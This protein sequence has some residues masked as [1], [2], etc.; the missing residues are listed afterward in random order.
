[1]ATNIKKSPTLKIQEE[2]INPWKAE[3]SKELC[4]IEY[5]S[6]GLYQSVNRHTIS[7]NPEHSEI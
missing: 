4:G 7:Y 1:M 6:F 3:E 2:D 5:P